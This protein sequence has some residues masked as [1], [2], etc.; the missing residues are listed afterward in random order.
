MAFNIT[1]TVCIFSYLERHV[2]RLDVVSPAD[3]ISE[4]VLA[5]VLDDHVGQPDVPEEGEL[6]GGEGHGAVGDPGV[7]LGQHVEVGE[8]QTLELDAVAG[9]GHEV[10]AADQSVGPTLHVQPG[11]PTA[12]RR[13]E[14][15]EESF[16]INIILL[17]YNLVSCL[18]ARF[19]FETIDNGRIYHLFKE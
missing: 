11:D 9:D 16:F 14:V 19:C 4:H 12:A 6:G 10:L 3:E 5:E 17:R 1:I 2:E 7:H 15:L 18:M 13:Q 8:G